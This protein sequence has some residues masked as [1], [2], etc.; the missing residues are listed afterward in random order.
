MTY[1]YGQPRCNDADRDKHK[2]SEKTCPSDTLSTINAMWTDMGANTG[3]RGDRPGTN[4][5]IQTVL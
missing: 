4:R 3:I 1:E 5:Q 2:N